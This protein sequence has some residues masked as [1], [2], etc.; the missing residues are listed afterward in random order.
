MDAKRGILLKVLATLAVTIMFACVR[1]LDGRIPTGEVVFFRSV[2]A[3]VPVV[4]WYGLKG[5]LAAMVHTESV[6]RHFGRGLTGTGGMFFNYLALA[7]LPLAQ[8]TAFSYAVPI[9]TVI[10]AALL[11]GEVVRIY[12]WSAVAV[13]LCGVLVML[14]PALMDS[15]RGADGSDALLIGAASA[16]FAAAC[17]ALSVIQIRR[18]TATEDPAAIVFWFT[19]LTTAL[20][21]ASLVFGWTMPDPRQLALLIGCGLFGGLAQVLMVMALRAAHASLLAP[22]DYVGM[23]WAVVVGY[24]AFAAVPDIYTLAGAIIVGGA[25]L[26]TIWRESRLRA[27]VRREQEALVRNP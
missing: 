23:L 24:F 12:R 14:L 9:F 26:F 20:G 1:S 27:L 22:F 21:L 2:F 15:I 10:F 5:R 19:V 13:G 11:L 8:L 3:L 18:M 17:S 7:Y 6:W 4:L 25:G 16:L